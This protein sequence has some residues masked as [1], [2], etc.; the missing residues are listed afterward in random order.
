MTSYAL[1]VLR[2]E[3]TVLEQLGPSNCNHLTPFAD[4][5]NI[6]PSRTSRIIVPAWIAF[7]Y[8]VPCT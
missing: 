2:I 3:M 5:A 6:S 7:Q 1:Y 4:I 8:L